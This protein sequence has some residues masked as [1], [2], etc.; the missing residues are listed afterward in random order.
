MM[1]ICFAER[2]FFFPPCSYYNNYYII[3]LYNNYYC[4]L[5][6]FG[7][8]AMNPL[9]VAD[10]LKHVGEGLDAWILPNRGILV[11]YKKI[12]IN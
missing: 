4:S 7:V 3:L 11:I 2:S 5:G 10:S 12:W 1:E 8:Q 6:G 9:K